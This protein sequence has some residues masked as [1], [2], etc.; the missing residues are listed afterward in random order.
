MEIESD[1]KKAAQSAKQERLKKLNERY[2]E[3]LLLIAK[4]E[5][6]TRERNRKLEERSLLTYLLNPKEK[7]NNSVSEPVVA[8]GHVIAMRTQE[9]S[10]SILLHGYR[11]K[12]T[13]KAQFLPLGNTTHVHSKAEVKINTC[14]FLSSVLAELHLGGL[15]HVK[16]KFLGDEYDIVIVQSKD[17]F[18]IGFVK[19][20][21]PDT[22]F[23]DRI[24]G[25]FAGETMTHQGSGSVAGQL[26]D[27]LAGL[28][29]VGAKNPLALLTNGN[30]WQLV[31]VSKVL[32]AE[33]FQSQHAGPRKPLKRLEH[34]ES[35]RRR[36][37]AKEPAT[38]LLCKMMGVFEKWRLGNREIFVSDAVNV[39]D[40]GIKLGTFI[41]K[42]IRLLI[43]SS[44]DRSV[45]QPRGI[46]LRVI[47][48]AKGKGV[49]NRNVVLVENLPQ[50]DETK[51][52]SDEATRFYLLEPLRANLGSLCYKA[53]ADDGSTCAIK[54]FWG[55]EVPNWDEDICGSILGDIE[56][57]RRSWNEIC[58]HEC[59]MR[60]L[61]RC[62]QIHLMV[63]Y[64][65]YVKHNEQISPELILGKFANSDA[66][67]NQDAQATD[68]GDDDTLPRSSDKSG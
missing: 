60:Q 45:S 5:A 9:F 2:A 26:F 42:V 3:S 67:S 21:L 7:Y 12:F 40:N 66:A 18:P 49:S 25:A 28:Q 6:E 37:A 4:L 39:M 48:Y 51:Y 32:P 15:Y 58:G 10:S 46:P 24:F 54:V 56:A 35:R 57:E 31:A 27:L 47:D 22:N 41:A 38:K 19:V 63:P 59:R 34:S 30:K 61:G 8:T 50:M 68:A 17:D 20:V 55:V 64:L 13:H 43:N 33:N 11:F 16:R 36:Q 29:I 52:P 14:N 44:K 62:N 65:Q 23:D 53:L 1:Q